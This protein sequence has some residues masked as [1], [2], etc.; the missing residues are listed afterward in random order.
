MT[1]VARLVS[2]LG[3]PF[4]TVLVMVGAVAVHFGPPAEAPRTMALVAAL[5]LL[6]VAALMIRQ[7]RRGSWSHVDASNPRERPILFAVGIAGVLL[8]LVYGLAFQPQSHLV[9][10]SLGTLIMLAFCAVATRWLKVS[11]HMAFNALAA[12][13]LLLL[14]SPAGWALLALMPILAWSRLYLGRHVLAEVMTGTV[15]GVA[16]GLAIHSL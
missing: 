5:A 13:S 12:T 7:V 11:L 10:G 6:P 3:H 14:A 15:I 2:I 4:A 16:S 9:R 1:V 8:L